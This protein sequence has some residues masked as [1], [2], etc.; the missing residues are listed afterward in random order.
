MKKIYQTPATNTLTLE[1]QQIIALSNVHDG[2][3]T[4]FSDGYATDG[5]DGLVKAHDHSYNIWDD[6]WSE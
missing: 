3:T 4:T 5:E 1:T 6:D 2:S